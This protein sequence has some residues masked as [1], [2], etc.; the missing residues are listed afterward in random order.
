MGNRYLVILPMSAGLL[1]TPS[2]ILSQ[3]IERPDNLAV[4]QKLFDE[5]AVH[6]VQQLPTDQASP[7]ILPQFQEATSAA[8]LLRARIVK[9][10][11]AK[12]S[13]VFVTDSAYA[14]QN[15][16]RMTN[17]L[18]RCQ[19]RY[20]QVHGGGLWRRRTLRR[21]ALV[22]VDV[23]VIEQP[24]GQFRLQDSYRS[25]FADTLRASEIRALE[26]LRFPFTIGRWPRQSVWVQMVEPA[27]LTLAAG[28]AIYALYSLRS[29]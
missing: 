12:G 26:N 25:E 4:F 3:P 27:L 19:V 22:E 13:T 21:Q 1:L 24:S 18:L 17:Q 2:V 11:L 28:A 16:L 8:G 10:L 7:V 14:E 15:Y 29:Q 23:E 20:E 5:L 6:L 9:Y